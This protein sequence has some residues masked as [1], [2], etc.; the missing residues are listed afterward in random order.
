MH[1]KFSHTLDEKM[2]DN[3]QS[4][5][6]LKFGDI[7]AETGSKIVAAQDYAINTTHFK[8]NILKEEIDSK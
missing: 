6:W 7:K 1:G 2:V 5:Q 4:C 8:N 3:E